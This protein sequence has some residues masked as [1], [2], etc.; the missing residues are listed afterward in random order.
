MRGGYDTVQSMASGETLHVCREWTKTL[1]T[2]TQ[3]PTLNPFSAEIKVNFGSENEG[4]RR[5]S[6]YTLTLLLT[7]RSRSTN[8][9]FLF[10]M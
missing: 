3:R 5:Q 6:R 8:I 9:N 7:A 1:A 4:E 10:K 2:G